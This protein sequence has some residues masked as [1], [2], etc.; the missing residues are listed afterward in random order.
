[1]VSIDNDELMI[2]LTQGMELFPPGLQPSIRSYST[3]VAEHLDVGSTG[4]NYLLS[5]VTKVIPPQQQ[6]IYTYVSDNCS[7]SRHRRQSFI[8]QLTFVEFLHR[9]SEQKKHP[10][11]N[12][13]LFVDCKLGLQRDISCNGRTRHACDVQEVPVGLVRY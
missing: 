1:M 4:S 11:W 3:H 10:P 6:S 2:M 9:N 8:R 13:E 12:S 7:I 5:L